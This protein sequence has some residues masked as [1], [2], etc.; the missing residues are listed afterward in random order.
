MFLGFRND[1]DVYSCGL[2]WSG[3]EK[4]FRLLAK[5]AK[6]IR[7]GNYKIYVQKIYYFVRQ[8][9]TVFETVMRVEGLL[10]GCSM[11]FVREFL[12]SNILYSREKNADEICEYSFWT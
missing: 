2:M 5:F 9:C 3:N 12:F 10:R 7:R 4:V 1:Y 8:L 6:K 11:A